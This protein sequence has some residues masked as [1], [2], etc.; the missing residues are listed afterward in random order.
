M[1]RDVFIKEDCRKMCTI[2][3]F[4]GGKRVGEDFAFAAE[5]HALTITPA[6]RTGSVE[7]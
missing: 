1:F 4:V 6:A 5:F 7:E 3:C 2:E